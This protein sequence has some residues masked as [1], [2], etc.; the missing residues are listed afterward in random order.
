MAN[1]EVKIRLSTTG[2]NKTE[3]DLKGVNRSIGNLAK[4][5]ITLA[6]AYK[7]V[8]FALESVKL[9]GKLADLETAHK[10]L[11]KAQGLNAKVMID[12]MQKATKG[13]VSELSLLQQAN[14][15]LL[16]G[17]P[18]SE[19]DMGKLADAGRRLGRAM[20]IDAAKGLESLVVGIGRQS[21][22]WLD[23]LG[24]IVDTDTAYKD[25]AK[26]LGKQVGALTDAEKKLAFYNATMESISDKMGQLGEDTVTMTD[27]IEQAGV[28][29]EKAKIKIGEMITPALTMWMEQASEIITEFT[30]ANESLTAEVPRVTKQLEKQTSTWE[31]LTG[32]MREAKK[33]VSEFKG[34]VGPMPQLVKPED[35]ETITALTEEQKKIKEIQDKIL[36]NQA[37]RLI[38]EQALLELKQQ[39]LVQFTD[40]ELAQQRLLEFENSRLGVQTRRMELME[41][42][43]TLNKSL[44]TQD[45]NAV[46]SS[47][48]QNK[49]SGL[50]VGQNKSLISGEMKV[51]EL[52]KLQ[53]PESRRTLQIQ[54]LTTNL[55]THFV[56][57]LGQGLVFFR[58]M[59]AFAQSM[60]QSVQR[61]AQELA[62]K[63][64]TSFLL[65]RVTGKGFL[66]TFSSIL[67][68]AD[69][70]RPPVGRPSVVGERGP[71]IFIP[72]RP[73]TI[74]PDAGNSLTINLNG[75]FHGSV[76]ELAEEIAERSEQNFNRISVNA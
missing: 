19:Q 12:Q 57:S 70:G 43:E 37:E 76:D 74:V 13:T 75:V 4:S 9:A 16:L 5:A 32:W 26:E 55:A 52:K 56:S 48:K 17:L 15:A 53:I 65:S 18:V 61:I 7:G 38:N 36:L 41:F 28:A 63:A 6:A 8:T 23:N 49:E 42:Q 54:L 40:E 45:M 58:G 27:K 24:I 60:L 44:A 68:F 51:L 69:G 21:K 2:K 62:A 50:A 67:G 10:A 39:G 14:N 22:L 72:D 29:F 59:S 33:E 34:F 3:R 1:K 66:D 35:L 73:G 71:E 64:F 11:S 46:K 30:E 20:G 25:F 31:F 47:V